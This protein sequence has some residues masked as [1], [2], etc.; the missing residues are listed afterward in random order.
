MT[1]VLHINKRDKKIFLDDYTEHR[2]I[3]LTSGQYIYFKVKKHLDTGDDK[4]FAGIGPVVF[5][6]YGKYQY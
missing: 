3:G 4:V 1:G 5:L 2:K 6:P